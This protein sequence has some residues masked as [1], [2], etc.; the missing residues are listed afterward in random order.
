[1]VGVVIA[2]TTRHTPELEKPFVRSF[3]GSAPSAEISRLSKLVGIAAKAENK[4]LVYGSAEGVLILNGVE[5]FESQLGI[6]G[7]NAQQPKEHFAT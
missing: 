2:L 6:R 5:R 7:Q 1:M 4:L 3:L